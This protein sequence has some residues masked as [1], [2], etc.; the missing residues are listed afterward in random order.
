MLTWRSAMA[1]HKQAPSIEDA[2]SY[3]GQHDMC[4]PGS[5]ARRANWQPN[6]IGKKQQAEDAAGEKC[7][8]MRL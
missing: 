3:K 8:G 1:P 6:G 5:I 2:A 4:M 7:R